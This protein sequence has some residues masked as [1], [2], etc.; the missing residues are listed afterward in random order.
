MAAETIVGRLLRIAFDGQ[1]D[2][3]TTRRLEELR[4]RTEVA[5]IIRQPEEIAIRVSLDTRAADFFADIARH[6]C[7][8]CAHGIAAAAIR[9]V[10][11]QCP[12]LRIKDGAAQDI[13]LCRTAPHIQRILRQR[14]R[15]PGHEPDD[16]GT[17]NSHDDEQAHRGLQDMLLELPVRHANASSPT[18][19]PGFPAG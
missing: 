17:E 8:S 3:V 16:V 7:E 15:L 10:L 4:G 19:L 13:G 6:G 1:I 5:D 9:P 11:C 14:V 12:S 18:T 2:V